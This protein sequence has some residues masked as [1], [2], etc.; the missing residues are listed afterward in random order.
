M[1]LLQL[2]LLLHLLLL[3]IINSNNNDD[4]ATLH[5]MTNDTAAGCYTACSGHK[6]FLLFWLV[7]L[8]TRC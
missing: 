2:L 1:L 8:A 7:V 4:Y 5:G 6:S 3:L